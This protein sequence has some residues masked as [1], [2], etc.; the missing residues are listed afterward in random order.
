VP[1][2]SRLD[3]HI[4]VAMLK[5]VTSKGSG[6]IPTGLIQAEGQTLLHSISTDSSRRSDLTALYQQH[7]QFYSVQGK[8]P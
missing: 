4:D 7:N 2:L 5:M 3:V 6:Q 1:G 8:F